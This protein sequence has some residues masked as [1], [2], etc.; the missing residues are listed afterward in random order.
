VE[1]I[2]EFLLAKIKSFR[3]PNT[4][5]QIMQHSV[6]L[7]YK[8]LN[9]FVMERHSEVATEIRQT[10]ANTLRWYFS[11]QFE[12]YATGLEKLQVPIKALLRTT[13]CRCIFLVDKGTYI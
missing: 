3:I 1:K 10:Y 7:K 12:N 8:E 2:R 9:Q 6:L 11:N 5:V 13:E 4:N